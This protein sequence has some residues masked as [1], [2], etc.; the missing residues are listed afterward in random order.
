MP[1]GYPTGI[2][3]AGYRAVTP[4]GYYPGYAPLPWMQPNAYPAYWGVPGANAR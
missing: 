1:P 3:G 4:V 2:Q